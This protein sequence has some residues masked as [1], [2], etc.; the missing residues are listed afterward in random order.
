LCVPNLAQCNGTFVPD[1]VG[2]NVPVGDICW[3]ASYSELTPFVQG[4]GKLIND[5]PPLCSLIKEA[6]TTIGSG[7]ILVVSNATGCADACAS[8]GTIRFNPFCLASGE[9]AKGIFF[10]ELSHIHNDCQPPIPFFKLLLSYA[11]AVEGFENNS[12]I[13]SSTHAPLRLVVSM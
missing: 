5:K 10:H 1:L 11:G 9:D 2:T 7:I 8:S 12:R 13:E 6:L 4:L 3:N